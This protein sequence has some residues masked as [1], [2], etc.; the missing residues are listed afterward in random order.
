MLAKRR[1]KDVV[2]ENSTAAFLSFEAVAE[3]SPAACDRERRQRPAA[4]IARAAT[5]D[6]QNAERRKVNWILVEGIR[7]RNRLRDLT[8]SGCDEI[9]S[10]RRCR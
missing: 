2:S 3:F 6:A 7:V 8:K 1:S 9:G 5:S 4:I 10:A